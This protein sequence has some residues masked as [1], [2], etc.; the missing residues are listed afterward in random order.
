MY[1][2][3]MDVR[4]QEHPTLRVL[5]QWAERS[6]EWI[7]GAKATLRA[8]PDPSVRKVGSDGMDRAIFPVAILLPTRRGP[9]LYFCLRLA[10]V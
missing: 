2:L 10:A 3:R 9:F 8:D 5:S 4:A 6:T 1:V 7:P